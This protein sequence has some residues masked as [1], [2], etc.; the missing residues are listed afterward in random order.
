MTMVSTEKFSWLARPPMM[1]MDTVAMP[2]E[3][4]IRKDRTM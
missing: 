1:G 4:G 2:E 3:D